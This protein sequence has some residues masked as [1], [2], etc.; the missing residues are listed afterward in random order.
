MVDLPGAEGPDFAVGTA[1][2]RRLVE[3][4][5]RR[6]DRSAQIMSQRYTRWNANDAFLRGYVD[7]SRKD[8]EG[9]KEYPYAR[10]IVVPYTYAVVQIYLTYLMAVFTAREPIFPVQGYGPEDVRAAEAM[11]HVLAYQMDRKDGTLMLH[12]FFQDVLRYSVGAMKVPW[13]VERSETTQRVP[14]PFPL[15]LV[16]GPDREVTT[17]SIG[18]EG[19]T[20]IPVDPFSFFPDPTVSLG[21]FAAHAEFAAHRII[22]SRAYIRQRA[23]EGIYHLE[24]VAKIP[25]RTL[26]D[27]LPTEGGEEARRD[28]FLQV[29]ALQA[30][31]P[32]DMMDKGPVLLEEMQIRLVPNDW[33]L[34]PSTRVEPWFLTLA[35]KEIVIRARRAPYHHQSLIYVMGT[36]GYD[37][38]AHFTQSLPEL[39][40]GLQTALTWLYNSH[41]ENVRRGLNIQA[42]YDPSMLET[43]DLKNPEAMKWI[44]ITSDYYGVPGAVERASKQ[45]SFVDVTQNHFRDMA[46]HL[47]M[48]QRVTAATDPQAGIETETRRTA[49]EVQNVLVQSGRRLQLLASQLS[50]Q[51]IRPL[52]RLMMAQTQQFMSEPVWVRLLGTA[53]KDLL[54]SAN[55]TLFRVSPQNIQGRFDLKLQDA[56]LPPDPARFAQVWKELFMGLSANANLQQ[57][58]A[59][60]GVRVRLTTLFKRTVEA[61]GIKN[62]GDFF[63]A[64]TPPQVMPDAQMAEQLQRGNLG[65]LGAG[66]NGLPAGGVAP[67]GIALSPEQ[68]VAGAP[69]LPLSRG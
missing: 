66:G 65:P 64:I 52:G 3:A 46:V 55:G 1:L 2:H 56:S 63:E 35:N 39:M 26:T 23:D 68:A 33:G 14:V 19:N 5:R 42:V 21:D 32:T 28:E 60:E 8:K 61:M 9:I 69:Q 54:R 43:E 50:S 11:E 38:H 25:V 49:T 6:I 31:E 48:I 10:S 22:R 45:L 20:L 44:R 34:G 18:Y 47:D 15:S 7:F 51:S 16:L 24:N 59:Q 13:E 37:P 29:S 62:I 40:E 36:F 30:H 4:I 41:M 67:V 27:L 58:F 17:E 12:G 53:S 57:A